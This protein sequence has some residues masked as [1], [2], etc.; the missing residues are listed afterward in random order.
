[1]TYTPNG[2][3]YSPTSEPTPEPV[4]H[5]PIDRLTRLGVVLPWEDSTPK[6]G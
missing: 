6:T 4:C 2:T 3:T 5:C 1:M